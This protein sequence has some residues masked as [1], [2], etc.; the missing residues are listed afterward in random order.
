MTCGIFS[1]ITVFSLN[2]NTYLSISICATGF[3]LQK[4]LGL[5]ELSEIG[6]SMLHR[7]IVDLRTTKVDD[8]GVCAL[9]GYLA[10][11]FFISRKQ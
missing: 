10:V 5:P 11:R 8:I 3:K 6:R 9:F 2:N 7:P 4:S 1:K